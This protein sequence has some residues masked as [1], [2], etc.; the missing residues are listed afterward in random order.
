MS[1]RGELGLFCTVAVAAI[2]LGLS[3]SGPLSGVTGEFDWS[4]GL[5][6]GAF[7]IGKLSNEAS[8]PL[9]FPAS[10]EFGVSVGAVTGGVTN[11][12]ATVVKPCESV[13]GA[14]VGDTEVSDTVEAPLLAVAIEL[15]GVLCGGTVDG[16]GAPR[17]G[18]DLG[19]CPRGIERG[20]GP[21]APRRGWGGGCCPV[22]IG[23]GWG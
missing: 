1:T 3:E 6:F 20:C 23:R 14:V 18:W 17:R 16:P 22:G 19:G 10:G 2:M 21:G 13:V 11:F 8:G 7:T 4:C 9:G 12:G 15:S 5:E